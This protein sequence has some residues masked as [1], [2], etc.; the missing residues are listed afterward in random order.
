MFG[1][2][3]YIHFLLRQRRQISLRKV[4]YLAMNTGQTRMEKK[5]KEY[6]I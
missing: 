3:A 4:M 2:T 1:N 5:L 6:N